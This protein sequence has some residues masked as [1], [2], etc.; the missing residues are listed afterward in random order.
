MPKI[1]PKTPHKGN[2]LLIRLTKN[3]ISSVRAFEKFVFSL[4]ICPR[5]FHLYHKTILQLT[6]C[7]LSFSVLPFHFALPHFLL[8][9]FTFLIYTL[10]HFFLPS[11]CY[12][13]CCFKANGKEL[14]YKHSSL[15][16]TPALTVKTKNNQIY[17]YEIKLLMS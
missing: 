5:S 8:I 9:L 3:G 12:L 13:C 17:F 10:I 6:L 16:Y 4:R 14:S 15:L 7:Y 1:P 2:C 11:L